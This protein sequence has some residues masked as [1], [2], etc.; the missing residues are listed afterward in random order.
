M[1]SYILKKQQKIKFKLLYNGFCS[2]AKQCDEDGSLRPLTLSLLFDHCFLFDAEQSSRIDHAHSLATFG[3]LLE[4]NR[5]M[6]L[7]HF[8]QEI[9]EDEE[10][11][12]KFKILV[13]N[14]DDI[15]PLRQSKKHLSGIS[16]IMEPLHHAA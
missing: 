14:L 4:K 9:I 2:L 3:T 1:A 16:I 6:A 10:P 11:K 5:A 7:C 13:D 12:E 8:I 15:F